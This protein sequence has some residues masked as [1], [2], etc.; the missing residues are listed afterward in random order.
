MDMK[1]YVAAFLITT[2]IFIIGLGVG[3]SFSESQIKAVGNRI[4]S[5]AFDVKSIDMELQILKSVNNESACSYLEKRLPDLAKRKTIL[6]EKFNNAQTEDNEQIKKEF[7]YSLVQYW[8]FL[9]LANEQCDIHQ[10][11]IL[12]FFEKNDERSRE[13]G[14]V[15]DYWVYQMNLH[16]ESLSVFGFDTELDEPLVRLLKDVY[17]IENV[18]A[19]VLDG[20]AKNEFLDRS[21]V[22]LLLCESYNLSVCS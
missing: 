10:P 22:R 16:N 20:T 19:V 21:A 8:T 4:S 18:P 9:K 11:I 6:A 17:H 5:L 13:Q 15:L 7:V 1:K 14:T 2:L 3:F 12:F